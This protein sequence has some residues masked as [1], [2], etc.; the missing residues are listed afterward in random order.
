MSP[1]GNRKRLPSRLSASVA[2]LLFLAA[3]TA[4]RRKTDAELGLTPQQAAGRRGYDNYCARCHEAYTS[5]DK[6]GPSLQGVFKRQYLAAS[7]LPASDQRVEEI[8]RY[9]RA[10][11]P[12]FSQALS[13]AQVKDILAYLKTL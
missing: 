9:G 2:I 10:K 3:C 11:M 7:G 1:A 5:G 12:A 13:E 8:I 4:A 6:Q